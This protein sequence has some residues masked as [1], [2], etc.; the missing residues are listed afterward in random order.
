MP[1][2]NYKKEYREFHGKPKQIKLRG[3][4]N[5]ARAVLGLLAGD[6]R[7]VDHK[8]PFSKGGSNKRNNLRAVSRSTNR[9]K[10]ARA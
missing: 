6:P 10:A 4:R 3:K 7:E 1:E 8:N 2:R 9:K 5:Q